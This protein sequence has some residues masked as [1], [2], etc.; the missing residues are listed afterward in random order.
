MTA[1]DYGRRRLV[2]GVAI[3]GLVAQAANAQAL[4]KFTAQALPFDPKT[5][6]GFSERLL[7]S[8]HDNNYVGAVKRLA[9]I[10]AQLSALDP[11]ATPNFQLNGLKREELI[12]WNSMILHELYFLSL[13]HI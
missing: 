2:V 12:A 1:I 11:N 10:E 8:H 5:I 6:T 4:P 9:A 3:S 13:I 7:V